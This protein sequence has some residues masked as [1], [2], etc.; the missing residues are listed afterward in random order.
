MSLSEKIAILFEVPSWIAEGLRSGSLI[1]RGGVIQRA[2]NNEI[3]MWLRE[4]K[5]LRQLEPGKRPQLSPE[6]VQQL[7]S[8]AQGNQ[9]LMV[10]QAANL[11][12]NV[13]GFALVMRKLH[14]MD[15]KL[16][17]IV[18]QLGALAGEMSWLDRRKDIELLSRV[19]AALEQAEWA[20]RTGRA[21]AQLPAV[22]AQLVRAFAHYTL[23]LDAMHDNQR[24]HSYPEL[25]AEYT[26]MAVMTALAIVRCDGVLDGADAAHAG[27]LSPAERLLTLSNR[28]RSALNEP[29]KH[30]HLLLLSPAQRERTVSVSRMLKETEVR[31]GGH[32]AELA[33]C[34]Q[35]GVGWRE[36]EQLGDAHPDAEMLYLVSKEAEK[37]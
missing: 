25:Y 9:A 3:V 22:R 8:L 29:R 13:I 35:S 23:L 36:W 1:R 12:V 26:Q 31:M 24:A 27:Y 19:V 33:W 5:R 14:A 4:G 32:A 16:D 18:D 15:K 2:K 20:E 11:A 6:V 17:Q 34:A 7:Q 10:V 28:Y 30:P 37:T 21:E